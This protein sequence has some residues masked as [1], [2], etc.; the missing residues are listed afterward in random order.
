MNLTNQ[1]FMPGR[2]ALNLDTFSNNSRHALL[3]M[4]FSSR[5]PKTFSVSEGMESPTKVHLSI[6]IV[7]N[8]MI[9]IAQQMIFSRFLRQLAGYDLFCKPDE[10]T[11][12]IVY[13]HDNES[14]GIANADSVKLL[15]KWF[16]VIRARV[17][18][19]K[20]LDLVHAPRPTADQAIRDILS[21]QFCLLPQSA[22]PKSNVDKVILCGSQTLE[23]YCESSFA[24][25][26][27]DAIKEAYRQ[28]RAENLDE[29]AL[30]KHIRQ[31]IRRWNH[32]YGFHHV[33]TELAFIEIRASEENGNKSIIPV[34]LNGN[35]E[36]LLK[37]LP[38]LEPTNLALKLDPEKGLYMLF[39]KL[40]QQI[41]PRNN[42]LI[43]C[44]MSCYV[45]ASSEFGR[46]RL[47]NENIGEII[48]KYT[49]RAHNTFLRDQTA[50]FRSIVSL[51]SRL[52]PPP[53][54]TT[55]PASTDSSDS[56]T[57][58]TDNGSPEECRRTASCR[59]ANNVTGCMRKGIDD[60]ADN[61]GQTSLIQAARYG[62]TAIVRY[63]LSGNCNRY[64]TDN[65]GR[66]ALSYAAGEGH[67]E[68]VRQML[69]DFGETKDYPDNEGRTA[70]SR[71][72]EMGHS[73]SVYHLLKAGSTPDI[74]DNQG[75]APL[76]WAAENGHC[77]SVELLLEA[78]S[79]CNATDNHGRNALLWA[80]QKGHSYIIRLL[81]QNGA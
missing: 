52:T 20:N 9:P 81:S 71:A 25:E 57:S 54:T 13:A 2:S 56:S 69:F 66:S 5:S 32:R 62:H 53:E 70:L 38:F 79:D 68:V 73:I 43:D 48:K 26:Y 64:A 24:G 42:T 41:S 46:V 18:S 44:Y 27:H 6:V 30:Q 78:G 74:A 45:A 47:T 50:H 51:D 4:F 61:N 19:D 63:L 7:T 60:I 75:R 23:I 16:K 35:N 21:N 31:V 40:V 14:N 67:N 10:P 15:I 12:F 37:Y 80:A 29:E 39:F 22:A 1:T 49:W 28:A 8:T 55:R 77:K 11:A 3:K 76:S 65:C 34:A 33:L 72:A 17:Y 36:S 59:P 58:S